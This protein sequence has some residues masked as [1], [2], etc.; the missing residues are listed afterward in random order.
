MGNDWLR[1]RKEITVCPLWGGGQVG[2]LKPAQTVADSGKQINRKDKQLKVKN[3][4]EG[5]K[6][7]KKALAVTVG[8]IK[9]EIQSLPLVIEEAERSFTRSDRRW[10]RGQK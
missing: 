3:P 5:K 9:G 8:E 6:K 7:K 10:G 4:E 2:R 1:Q